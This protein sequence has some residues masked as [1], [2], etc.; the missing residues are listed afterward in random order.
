[1]DEIK[2][3]GV[4]VNDR[5]GQ[6]KSNDRSID[7][8]LEEA[9]VPLRMPND[10]FDRLL[11]AANFHGFDSLE[12]YLMFRLVQTLETKVGAASIDSPSQTSGVEARKITG[13]SGSG[14]VHRA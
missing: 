7:Y 2:D 4:I 8:N 9:V 11:K 6:D 5:D 3:F 14:M 10:V 13:P 1:M 12:K